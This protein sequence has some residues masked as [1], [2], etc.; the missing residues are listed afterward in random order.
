MIA[1]LVLII[2]LS[3]CS[4]YVRPESPEEKKLAQQWFVCGVEAYLTPDGSHSE[5]YYSLCL[6][7]FE[8]RDKVFAKLLKTANPLAM[9]QYETKL[10]VKP[11]NPMVGKEIKR[12]NINC[13]ELRRKQAIKEEKEYQ[14]RQRRLEN[15]ALYSCIDNG[16]KKGTQAMATCM[17]AWNAQQQQEQMMEQQQRMFKAQQQEQERQRRAEAWKNIADTFQRNTPTYTNCEAW[18]STMH[19]TTQ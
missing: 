14:A 5:T 1:L 13:K 9:C 8:Q 16:F 3:G 7:N 2:T 12:R 17:A 19:C 6:K 10:D 11:Q 15:P 4:S 18:G